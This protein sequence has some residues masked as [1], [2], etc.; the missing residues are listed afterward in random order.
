MHVRPACVS[1]AA[2]QGGFGNCACAS[3]RKA[4][5]AS[6][7]AA[8]AIAGRSSPRSPQPDQQVDRQQRQAP[9][10][11]A[12]ARSP[13]RCPTALK[14]LQRWPPAP[15][16][17][18]PACRHRARQVQR[19]APG[20]RPIQPR[21][22]E[23][24]RHPSSQTPPRSQPGRGR[25]RRPQ[26][27]EPVQRLRRAERIAASGVAATPADS[28]TKPLQHVRETGPISGRFD[29]SAFAV[30]WNSTTRPGAA[31]RLRH[32]RRAV[33][34]PGPAMVGELRGGLAPAPAALTVHLI[35]H[36][37]PG[38]RRRWAGTPPI[39]PAGSRTAPRQAADPRPAVTAPAS[40][41][42]TVACGGGVA[43]RRGSPSTDPAKRI[44]SAAML[45]PGPAAPADSAAD[46]GLIRQHHHPRSP[47]HS[48]VCR[49]PR[50]QVR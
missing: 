12:T 28:A 43:H 32:Q 45:D 1:S 21:R 16:R 3:G 35:G 8:A 15:A 30:T 29:Q 9:P 34:Q 44:S 40:D 26:H 39:W 14:R 38:E 37:Q 13:A 18:Q 27:A 7:S 24:G 42:S 17:P 20:L 11:S 46:T 19:P 36:R 10:R 31:G 5:P 6:S 41:R 23:P 50:A 25:R 4:G 49:S 22:M 47:V 48:S 2:C 33:G